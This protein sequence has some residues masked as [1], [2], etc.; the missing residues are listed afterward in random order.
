MGDYT[1]EI[2]HDIISKKG[3]VWVAGMWLEDMSHVVVVTA[4]DP[5]DGRIRIVNPWENYDLSDK[6]RTVSR[7]NARG[8]LWKSYEGSVMYW[9]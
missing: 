5:E 8:N 3:P 4:C 7:F 6:L 1:P 9:K 2:L